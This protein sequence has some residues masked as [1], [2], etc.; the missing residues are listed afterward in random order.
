MIGVV[1]ALVDCEEE[2]EVVVGII[3]L[4]EAPSRVAFRTPPCLEW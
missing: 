1:M 4:V 3:L 2:E